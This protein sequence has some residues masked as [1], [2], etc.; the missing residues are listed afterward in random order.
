VSVPA[1]EYELHERS[2]LDGTAKLAAFVRR[3]FL[4]A[5]SYRTA[6]VA[7]W[8]TLAFQ[9][10]MFSLIGRLIDPSLLPSYGGTQV[11]YM[12]FVSIGI[13]VAA[14]LSLGLG[15]VA[16]GMR[17]EQL[18]GTLEPLLLTPTSPLTIQVGTVL[19]DLLFIPVRL[20]IFL[21]TVAV[22]FGLHFQASGVL[23]ALV[24]LFAL[25]PFV[26]GLGIVNAASVMTFRRGG[27][28]MGF[29]MPLIALASGAYFPLA[30]LPH[31]LETAVRDTPVALALHG[32][33]QALIGGGG[34]SLIGWNLVIIGLSSL[35][36]VV[37]GSV[38]FRLALRRE[39]RRGSL[40]LY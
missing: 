5:W 18:M 26:W 11:S 36:F 13:A 29:L 4:V 39:H 8:T 32:I 21:T 3:D 37:L 1:L 31:W 38:A 9:V 22:I 19:Y 7:E 27:M 15:R 6:F 17:G 28:G 2:P 34:W 33:R 24:F 23:P 35:L 10:A 30:V 20:A 25:M 12:Q 16:T 40:G 14:V